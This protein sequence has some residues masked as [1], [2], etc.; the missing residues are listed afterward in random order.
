MSFL[1][2]NFLLDAYFLSYVHVGKVKLIFNHCI[3]ASAVHMHT[4][5]NPFSLVGHNR[6]VT[7]AQI[8]LMQIFRINYP[9]PYTDNIET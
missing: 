3:S 9:L 2:Y 5:T 6:R 8:L 7:F 1:Q 4:R